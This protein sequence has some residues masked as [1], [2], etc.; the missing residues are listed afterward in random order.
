[1]SK[2]RFKRIAII[3]LGGALIAL[4]VAFFAFGDRSQAFGLL[5]RL[6]PVFLVLAGAVR[7]TGFLLDRQP[8]SPVG[9]MLVI[10]LGGILLAAGFREEHGL[11]HIF[12]KYWFF[13]LL[14]FIAGRVIAEYGRTPDYGIK[15]RPFVG[16]TLVAALLI[17]AAGLGAHFVSR[18]P[19]LSLKLQAPFEKLTGAS[20]QLLKSEYSFETRL[21]NLPELSAGSRFLVGDFPGDIVVRGITS[22]QLRATLVKRVSAESEEIGRQLVDS[23]RVQIETRGPDIWLMPPSLPS[24]QS[25]TVALVL[26]LPED[27]RA[28]LELNRS[29][30]S[31]KISGIEASVKVSEPRR[32]VVLR[33]IT[34]PITID[35]GNASIEIS[36]IVG[37]LNVRSTGTE[38]VRADNITG[39]LELRADA[40]GVEVEDTRGPVTI[41]AQRNVKVRR[42]EGPIDVTSRQGTV[43]MS[44]EEPPEFDIVVRT[45][46]SNAKIA[47]PAPSIFRLDAISDTGRI[48]VRG[49]EHLELPQKETR[50]SMNYD[51]GIPAP[52]ISV[53]TKSGEISI[54]SSGKALARSEGRHE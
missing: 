36:N 21:E 10:A 17:S 22:P 41:I 5:I 14:A 9:G 50:T 42:F 39:A 28:N 52:L 29:R 45:E 13:L 54:M 44:L 26:E 24:D 34:G 15:R 25:L 20:S 23:V 32:G 40:G 2:T 38:P 18:S 11:L 30:G 3:L 16:G 6:W 19:E 37:D 4:G 49:F 48:R 43:E 47:I 46:K 31:V 27:T 12:G 51:P 7:V 35:R 33:D 53:R 8:R 1:M